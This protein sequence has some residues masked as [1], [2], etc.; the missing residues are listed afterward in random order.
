MRKFTYR[1]LDYGC[2]QA[3]M[4]YLPPL[5][6]AVRYRSRRRRFKM[7]SRARLCLK[8]WMA[9]PKTPQRRK[10]MLLRNRVGLKHAKRHLKTKQRGTRASFQRRM[11]SHGLWS[12]RSRVA[13]S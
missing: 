6:H 5:R 1:S 12:L 10:R 4:I 9:N 8:Q 2:M 7:D 3:V 13:I 11:F